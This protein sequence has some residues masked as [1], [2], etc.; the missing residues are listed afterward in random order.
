MNSKNTLKYIVEKNSNIAMP[1]SHNGLPQRK[2]DGK[3]YKMSKHWKGEPYEYFYRLMGV[4]D[5]NEIYDNEGNLKYAAISDDAKKPREL[6]AIF[7]GFIKTKIINPI[8]K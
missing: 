1:S 3:I 4:F 5:T 8:K 7:K 6:E 2:I